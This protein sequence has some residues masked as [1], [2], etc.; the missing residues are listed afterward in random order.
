MRLYVRHLA[1]EADPEGLRRLF[2]HYLYTGLAADAAAEPGSQPAT[3]VHSQCI[4]LQ[5][6]GEANLTVAT[7]SV[8]DS[9]PAVPDT[10]VLRL[11]RGAP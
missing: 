10:A 8:A 11:R 3:G 9:G 5:A 7:W 4:G 2:D 1:P 6:G